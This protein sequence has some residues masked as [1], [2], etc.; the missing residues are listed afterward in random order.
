MTHLTCRNCNA[1]FSI[2]HLSDLVVCPHCKASFA[3][4]IKTQPAASGAPD[5]GSDAAAGQVADANDPFAIQPP[6][7]V[8]APRANPEGLAPARTDPALPPYVAPPQPIKAKAA[9]AP[10]AISARTKKR[11]AEPAKSAADVAGEEQSAP[12]GA[13][14]KSASSTGLVLAGIGGTM[15]VIATVLLILGPL[16]RPPVTAADLKSK[17]DSTQ[18]ELDTLKL[19]LDRTEKDRARLAAESEAERRHASDLAEQ[20]KRLDRS[21]ETLAA[22]NARN[23]DQFND[24][25]AEIDKARNANEKTLVNLGDSDPTHW[26]PK[27]EKTVVVILTDVGSG[28]GFLINNSGLVVT[29][30]HVVEGSSKISAKL[31]RR[32]SREQMT[33]ENVTVLAVDP[34]HDLA[35]VQLPV[36]CAEIGEAGKYPVATLRSDVPLQAGENVVVI[37]NPGMQ[38]VILD[39]TV[40]RGIVSN[41]HRAVENRTLMQISAAVNPGNSGGP[42]FDTRGAVIG[43]VV[44]KGINVEAITFAIPASDVDSLVA[45]K[46]D[47]KFAVKDG[48]ANWEKVNRPV[49]SLERKRR[50]MAGKPAVELTTPTTGIVA[51]PDGHTFHLLFGLTGRIQEFDLKRRALGR[52]FRAECVLAG[53]APYGT[54]YLLTNS[55]ETSRT[56]RIN[57]RTMSLDGEVKTP[58]PSI[59]AVNWGGPANYAL[60][61][62]EQ[63][64]PWVINQGSFGK[65]APISE[66]PLEPTQSVC[67]GAGSTSRWVILANIS[68][69]QT[70]IEVSAFPA[71]IQG[72]I[73]QL[74]TRVN[75]QQEDTIRKR[76]AVNRKDFDLSLLVLAQEAKLSHTLLTWNSPDHFIFARREFKLGVKLECEGGFELSSYASLPETD[77]AHDASLLENIF[78]VTNDGKYAASGY[79]VYDASTRKILKELPFP[80]AVHA[81]TVDG[82]GMIIA[83]GAGVYYF[84]DWQNSFPDP[85]RK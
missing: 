71:S 46:T 84:E 40:T 25:Q 20:N 45:R 4:R 43:V 23:A 38:N 80:S 14:E 27:A 16:K 65:S 79:C 33:L 75:P 64:R 41:A 9:V 12:V 35:L 50:A 73:N 26:I 78:S 19:L 44:A 13:L 72:D 47:A 7:V 82:K 77:Q 58:G 51:S 85:E 61:L 55:V 68:A 29:N 15:L 57:T 30:Y 32:D 2:E 6:P 22:A 21:F 5:H 11:V 1:P 34:V 18:R 53:I 37:G 63:G 48:L 36:C 67:F 39:Y 83:G 62:Q 42:V 74:N 66:W 59:R 28:S 24:R 60:L 54:D 76:L 31:Q 52:E 70:T 3:V 10:K 8:H 69:G 81:F 17:T 56:L 49:A